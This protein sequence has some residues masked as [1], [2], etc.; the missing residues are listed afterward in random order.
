[1]IASLDDDG[2]DY[3]VTDNKKAS[4]KSSSIIDCGNG[5]ASKTTMDS[6]VPFNM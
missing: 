3:S 4:P 6:K 1:L 5:W 2:D